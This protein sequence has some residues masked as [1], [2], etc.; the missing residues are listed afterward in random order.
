MMV[1]AGIVIDP[2]VWEIPLQLLAIAVALF[3][4]YEF[5]IGITR[6]MAKKRNRDPLGW[7]LLSFFISPILTWI[8]LLIVGKRN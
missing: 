8:L 3:L 1:L 4:F 7:V 5:Y 2:K 6:C